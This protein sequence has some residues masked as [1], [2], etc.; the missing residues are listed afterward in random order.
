[1]TT[2]EQLAERRRAG[3]QLRG[4]RLLLRT[5]T[6]DDA[7]ALDTLLCTDAALR[8]AL[9]IQRS[10][11]VDPEGWLEDSERWCRGTSSISFAIVNEAHATIGLIS[12]SHIDRAA[13]DGEIGYWLGSAHWGQGYGTEAFGLVLAY[14]RELGLK[15]LSATVDRKNVASWRIWLHYGAKR[16]IDDEGRVEFAISFQGNPR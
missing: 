1:M 8:Q 4:E 3:V 11:P 15:K 9:G 13:A 10:L 12:L 16:R 7:R 2:P 14:A 5:P 6:L